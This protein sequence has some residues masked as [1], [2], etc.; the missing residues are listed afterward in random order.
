MARVLPHGAGSDRQRIYETTPHPLT[1]Y[2]WQCLLLRNGVGIMHR[3]TATWH[4][5]KP[6]SGQ[7]AVPVGLASCSRGI[8]PQ[9][10][11]AGNEGLAKLPSFTVR[12]PQTANSQFPGQAC[13]NL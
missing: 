2:S 8:A 13:E 4:T 12:M 5:L 11:S 6:S 1:G 3:H 10:T 9:V 7:Q